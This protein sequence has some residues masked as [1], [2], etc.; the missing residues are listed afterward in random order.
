MNGDRSQVTVSK[1]LE[2]IKEHYSS[3]KQKDAIIGEAL[4]DEEDKFPGA[5]TYQPPS[6]NLSKNVIVT[7]DNNLNVSGYIENSTGDDDDTA[8]Y[9][10]FESEYTKTGNYYY[11]EPDLSGFNPE[12]TYYVTYDE[13]GNNETVLGRIDLSLIHI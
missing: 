8:R 9:D 10:I 13:N 11:Y 6:V 1:T 4:G 7:V 12:A 5:I 3:Q 2:K